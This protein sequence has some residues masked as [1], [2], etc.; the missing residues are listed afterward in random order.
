MTK[1]ILLLIG[2]GALT[3]VV[4]A[5]EIY[6][7]V[8]EQGRVH[9]TDEPPAQYERKAEALDLDGVQTY[10]GARVQTEPRAPRREADQ[11]LGYE[12]VQLLRP[13]SEQTIRDASHTL[14]V[15]VQLV[16]PLRTKLG[17][18]LQF[19]LDGQPAG[20]PTSSTSQTLTE[21][22]RGTHTVQ[23]VVVDASGRQIA[24]TESRTVYMKPPS[25]N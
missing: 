19:F 4:S 8:D 7:Y 21:V 23:A 22:Y 16:P 25:V 6:R 1:H 5:G 10:R 11:V 18:R 14:T 12:R 17:H 13:S 3:G 2:L 20:R 9:Y 24:Q 15:S